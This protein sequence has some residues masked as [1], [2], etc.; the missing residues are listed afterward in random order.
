MFKNRTYGKKTGTVDVTA[1]G[2]K[3]VD[4]GQIRPYATLKRT[5]EVQIHIDM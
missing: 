2:G 4:C 5:V 1:S 3:F